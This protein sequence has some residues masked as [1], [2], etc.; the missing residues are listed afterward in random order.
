MTQNHNQILWQPS[1]QF[2]E[3]SNLKRYERW[4]EEHHGLT[5]NSYGEMWEWSAEDVADFWETLWRYFEI[6]HHTPYKRVLSTTEMP[7]ARWFEG[8]T[9]NYAEHIFRMKS[10]GRPAIQFRSE[11]GKTR[12]IGW[13]E[14]ELKVS[15]VRAWLVREGIGKGDR[16]AGY[17]PNIPEAMIAFYA[18]NSLGAVWSCCSPDFG[19]KTVIDRFAQIEPAILFAA[20]GYVYGGKRHSRLNEIDEIVK[21]ISSIRKTVTIQ[22]FEGEAASRVSADTILWGDILQMPSEGLSFTPVEFND[23]IWVLYS[24]G[25]TGKPKAITHSQGGVLLEHLK[26]LHFH[27]DVKAGENFFWYTTTGWMMWNFMQASLLSGATAVLYDGSAGYPNLDMLWKH[28]SELPIHHFGTSAPYI[29]AC[30]KNGLEPGKEFDLSNLRSI[31]STGSPLPS[32]AFDWVYESV[33]Q[34]IWLCSMSGGTD[35]CTAFVGGCPYEPVKRGRIQQRCLGVDLHAY[36]DDGNEITGS[37]GEMVIRK[38]MPSMPVFFWGDESYKR[39]RE[40]YFQTFKGVWRHGDWIKLFED[41]TLMIQG[42]SDATLNRKGIRIGTAEIYAVLN[43]MEG[44]QDSIIVNLEREGGEDYMPLY[45][46]IDDNVV[47]GEIQ[48]EIKQ[49]LK[50]ECS[51]RHVPDEVIPVPAIPY[52]LSGKKMEVPVKK[53]LMGMDVSKAMNTDAMKNPEAMEV[54]VK[55]GSMSL[56]SKGGA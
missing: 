43:R 14:L 5:F 49:E 48:E 56:P 51:P 2:I 44:V 15:A 54:F 25:T 3:N 32:E 21:G 37:L 6:I 26:Y 47:V 50:T 22:E 42:R 53:A 31:G 1:D 17:L 46:V 35:M 16:V 38:P 41:G 52:T 55:M 33:S 27:N 10:E 28:A 8:A 4:L 29:T 7:G 11:T 19:V 40:S 36:D 9:L 45:V 13:Q 12:T 39:Y 30:M 20:R 23:P 24:S 18:V 34:D